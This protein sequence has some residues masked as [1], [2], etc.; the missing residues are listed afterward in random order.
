MNLF[1]ENL[2]RLQACDPAL[3]KRVSASNNPETVQIILAKDGCLV[4]RI[5]N[6]SLHSAYRPKEEAL[7]AVSEIGAHEGLE[8]VVFGLGF[9]YHVTAMLEKF[10]GRVTVVEPSMEIFQA[11]L[12]SIDL[13]SF[14]PR[15]RFLIAEP[16]P[17]ILARNDSANWNIF[18]YRSEERRVGK[19][20][21]SRW[22]PYH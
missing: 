14:L 22:S 7:R 1:S 20:C 18:R 9:G 2:I 5:G 13:Q 15:T 17:K 19:E 21:R 11:F 4:P 12:S 10:P 6:V 8:S 3:A 16:T